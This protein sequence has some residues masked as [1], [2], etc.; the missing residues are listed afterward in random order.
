MLASVGKG[1]EVEV[2]RLASDEVGVCELVLPGA[3]QAECVAAF[4][5]MEYSER[6]LFLGIAFSPAK[7]ASPESAASDMTWLLRSIDQS[8]SASAESSA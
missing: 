6:K 2:D 7:S 8:L 5:A 1:V 3:E 4:E